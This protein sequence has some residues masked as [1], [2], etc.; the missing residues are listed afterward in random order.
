M[1]KN[2][3]KMLVSVRDGRIDF[4]EFVEGTRRDFQLMALYLLNRWRGP[5]WFTLD[6]VEQE[7]YLGAW[8]F[9]WR[10]EE[11]R[12][13]TLSRY[14]AFNALA[15]AKTH[16]H[17]ARGVTI[18]GSPDRKTSQ[19]EIPISTMEVELD[20]VM[21]QLEYATSPEDKLME[22]QACKQAATKVLKV[23]ETRQERYAVLAI[24]EAGSID[25]AGKLIY[26]DIDHRIALRLG[27]EEHAEK[28][29]YRH[30]HAVVQRL[31]IGV[32]TT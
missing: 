15:A 5:E 16:L 1:S 7:L 19:I 20:V 24:R 21:D 25:G 13:T 2:L 31:Q 8:N 27:S 10:Y 29:I 4:K 3:E 30:A 14:V 18:S 12:G 9:I 26:D 22:V 28:F 11:N 6:D 23:C 32:G 17:K